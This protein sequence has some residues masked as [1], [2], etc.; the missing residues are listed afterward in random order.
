MLPTRNTVT[1]HGRGSKKKS[2]GCPGGQP[3]KV[4]R[5]LAGLSRGK[6]DVLRCT[7]CSACCTGRRRLAGRH[8]SLHKTKGGAIRYPASSV[9]TFRAYFKRVAHLE[10]DHIGI[11]QPTAVY[12]TCTMRARYFYYYSC[13]YAPATDAR[14]DR[15][16]LS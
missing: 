6:R 8:H 5:E 14:A 2:R 4:I 15:I 12:T 7:T 9:L 11:H 1:S 3:E 16:L 10:R 13:V